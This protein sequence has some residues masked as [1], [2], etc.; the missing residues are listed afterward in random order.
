M[1]SRSGFCDRDRALTAWTRQL[2]GRYFKKAEV[3][4]GQAGGRP[5]ILF[6][7]DGE[8]TKLFGDATTR[9]KGKQIG[10]FLDGQPITQPTVQEAITRGRG[11]I[12]GSF[13]LEEARSFV[14]QL[15]AGALPCAGVHRGGAHR[16]RHAWR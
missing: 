4:F 3:G 14:I 1:A 8:G 7:F 10:I 15:N 6:E 11:V 2:T 13:T 9:L 5:E 16:R 12:T